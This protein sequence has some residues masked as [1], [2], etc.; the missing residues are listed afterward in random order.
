MKFGGIKWK[1]D[2][3]FNVFVVVTAEFDAH[4]LSTFEVADGVFGCFN[5]PW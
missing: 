2:K 1:L 4:V 5:V 3:G